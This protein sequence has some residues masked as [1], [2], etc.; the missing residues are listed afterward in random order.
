MSRITK[1]TPAQQDMLPAI[2]G[3]WLTH[4]LSTA[5]ADRAAAGQ[6]IRDA[7]TAAGLQ[8]PRFIIW[9][10]SPWAGAIAQAIT[11][12]IIA[13]YMAGG[14]QVYDQVYD[15]VGAQVDDQVGTQVRD[16]V[17]A[18][19]G[20][21]VD[22]QV[23][24]QVY[25]QVGAQVYAQVRDQ[26]DAQVDDQVRDQV[27]DQVD[28]QVDAQ[29]YAQVDDQVRAQV[30]DQVDAQVR[31]QVG[32]RLQYWYQARMLGQHWAGYYAYYD[33][34]TR[35][36]VT[37]L[38]PIQ[39]QITAARAAGWWWCYRHFTIITD[40]PERLDRDANGALHSATG[41]AIRYRDGWGFHAW[42]GRRVPAWVIEA[43]TVE[44]IAAEPNVEIRR[45]AI[46]AMGW[47]V[48]ARKAEL[49]L[50]GSAPDPGNYGCEIQLFDVPE[51]LWGSRIRLLLATNGSTERSGERR[52][53]GL[54]VPA[55]IN[56]PVAAAAWTYGL[57]AAEYAT[58]QRRT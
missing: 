5:P 16:Q 36:G 27:Y 41:P 38:E 33:T 20:A 57:T 29:V 44:A 47:D 35:L 46:E 7:Y 18:Q 3:E 30:Y 12:A 2:R 45:C 9:L 11:P 1:L 15:Q 54:T 31:D 49:A 13:P 10:G 28:A 42:H 26:V 8:P 53:Y 32:S 52:K 50:V 37:G 39:G 25:D 34:M 51:R 21:Q 56:D 19:V 43:P 58:C 23:R 6:G 22:D 48:F 17:R 24:D 40:R 4:G 55:A 14:A